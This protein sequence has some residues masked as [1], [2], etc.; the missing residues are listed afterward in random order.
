MYNSIAKKVMNKKNGDLERQIEEEKHMSGTDGEFT[1][2]HNQNPALP[3]YESHA[4]I[5]Q[6]NSSSITEDSRYEEEE[7]YNDPNKPV[8]F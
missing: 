1:I 7:D 3:K 4:P 8:I 2:S 6:I 5:G